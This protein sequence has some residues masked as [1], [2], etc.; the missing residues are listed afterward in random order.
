MSYDVI[1]LI[2][3]DC[4]K[5]HLAPEKFITIHDKHYYKLR[6]FSLL[7]FTTSIITNCDR[8]IIS[9]CDKIYYNSRQRLLQFTTI[10]TI[11]DR[12]HNIYLLNFKLEKLLALNK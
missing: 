1:T 7:K 3:K 9:I 4:Q 6:Q 12:T 5:Q 2:R 10:I 8:S 11:Y